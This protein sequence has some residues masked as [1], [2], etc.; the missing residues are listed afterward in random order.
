MVQLLHLSNAALLFLRLDKNDFGVIADERQLARLHLFLFADRTAEIDLVQMVEDMVIVSRIP[1]YG[2]IVFRREG[3]I[4][5]VAR[6]A[7]LFVFR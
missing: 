5:P 6:H 2:K 4:I 3:Q 1:E 7:Q